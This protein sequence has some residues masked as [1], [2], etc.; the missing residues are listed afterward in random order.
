M[1]DLDIIAALNILKQ[2]FYNDII[3]IITQ[4]LCR[5]KESFTKCDTLD[6]LFSHLCICDNSKKYY[7]PFLGTDYTMGYDTCKSYNHS[8]ICRSKSIIRPTN[9]WAEYLGLDCKSK[10]HEC[11]CFFLEHTPNCKSS[12]HQGIYGHLNN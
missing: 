5:C 8:C 12:Q 1:E 10:H 11:I 4:Y 9:L 2:Y 7:I 3:T 6:T